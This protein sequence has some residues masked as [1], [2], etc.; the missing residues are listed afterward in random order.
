MHSGNWASPGMAVVKAVKLAA[1][2]DTSTDRGAGETSINWMHRGME[3]EHSPRQ[4]EH[5]GIISWNQRPSFPFG[6]RAPSLQA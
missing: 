3:S 6:E 4:G 2:L 1:M 5:Q